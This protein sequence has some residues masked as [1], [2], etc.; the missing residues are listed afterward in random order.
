MSGRMRIMTVKDMVR[1]RGDAARHTHLVRFE[2]A[3]D[4][5]KKL[6]LDE[7]CPHCSAKVGEQCHVGS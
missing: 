4:R 3:N 2:V 7:S 6:V 1:L 5:N